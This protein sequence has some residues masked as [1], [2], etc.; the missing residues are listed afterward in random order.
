M[1]GTSPRMTKKPQSSGATGGRAAA[2]LFFGAG[3]AEAFCGSGVF[4]GAGGGGA[5]IG[6]EP[7]AYI[8]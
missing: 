8:T 3:A 4:C 7:V 6:I 2:P 5:S 1:R